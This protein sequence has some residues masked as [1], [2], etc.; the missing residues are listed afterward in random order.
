MKLMALR[1][2]GNCAACGVRIEQ[3]TEA[4]YDPAN[5]KVMCTRCQPV[6]AQLGMDVSAA[7]DSPTPPV[8]P[9]RTDLEKGTELEQKIADVFSAN[10]YRVQTNVVREGRSGASHEVDVLAEKT[11]DLLTL[12]VA[13]ECKA[14]N[15]PIEKDVIAKFNEVRRDLGLGHALVVSL[16]GARAGALTLAGELGVTIWGLDEIQA[17]VGRSA[18]VGLQNRPMVEEVGFPR[19]LDDAAASALIAKATGGRMGI[20]KEEVTWEGNAWIPVALVQL[21]LRKYGPFQRKMATSQTWAVYDLVGR[22][23]VTRLDEEPDRTPVAMDGPRL[24]QVLKL[25]EPGK[26]LESIIA[27]WDKA[28]GEATIQKYR[29]EMDLLGVPAMHTATVGTTTAFLYPVRLAIAS[30][31]GTERV[32]VVDCFRGRLDDDLGRACSKQ[33]AGVRSSIGA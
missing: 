33:I 4:W 7:R 16:N 18:V 5:K 25:T 14:W 20:G 2:A 21:T 13:I 12:S 29:H 17:H 8:R 26:S 24:E 22:S 9:A 10:G 31:N 11:D 15:S 23:F 30:R 27:K 32:V 3:R 6:G 1:Y 19:E 28:T